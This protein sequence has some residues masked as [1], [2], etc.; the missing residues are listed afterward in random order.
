RH[1]EA[2]IL[3]DHVLGLAPEDALTHYYLGALE[4]NAGNW[5]ASLQYNNR[6]LALEPSNPLALLAQMQ[7]LHIEA[8]YDSIA[9]LLRATLLKLGGHNFAKLRSWS[10]GAEPS[11]LY[12]PEWQGQSLEGKAIRL[13]CRGGLGY[14]IQHVRFARGLKEQGATVILECQKPLRDVMR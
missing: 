8:K 1:E 12:R 2:R 7:N 14:T 6:A 3:Y 13:L 10:V 11:V 5:D 9:K 4:F